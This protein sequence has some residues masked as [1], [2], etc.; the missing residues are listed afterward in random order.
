[1]LG[2][3]WGRLEKKSCLGWGWFNRMKHW[4][5]LCEYMLRIGS[6]MMGVLGI[7]NSY[8]IWFNFVE[9]LMLDGDHWNTSKSL[10]L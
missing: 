2:I 5:V 4:V 3:G 9:S 7:S 8:W 10:K 6:L 1:M